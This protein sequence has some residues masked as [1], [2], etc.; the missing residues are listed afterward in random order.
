MLKKKHCGP[1]SFF[2]VTMAN[3]LLTLYKYGFTEQEPAALMIGFNPTK[4]LRHAPDGIRPF[5]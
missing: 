5:R 1:I 3:I 2:P 4:N